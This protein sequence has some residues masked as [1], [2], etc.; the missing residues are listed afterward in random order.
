MA[1]SATGAS[2]L[3]HTTARAGRSSR[4]ARTARLGP[5]P[6]RARR[7]PGGRRAGERRLGERDRYLGRVGIGE[8]DERRSDGRRPASPS[9]PGRRRDHGD[10]QDGLVEVDGA[11]ERQLRLRHGRQRAG[12]HGARRLHRLE[13]RRADRGDGRRR[14]RRPAHEPRVLRRRERDR[15]LRPGR[16]LQRRHGGCD[17]ARLAPNASRTTGSPIARRSP[18]RAVR[19]TARTP[20]P[21]STSASP[22]TASS[23]TTSV[24]Y[25][26]TPAVDGDATLTLTSGF[27]GWVAVYTGTAVGALNAVV[28]QTGPTVRSPPASAPP[29]A[30]TYAIQV[31]AVRRRRRREHSRSDGRC[32]RSGRTDARLGDAREHER[33]ARLERTVVDRRRRDHG[34]QDLPRHL[35]AATRRLLTTVGNVTVF[36]DTNVVERRDLLVP[37]DRR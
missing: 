27:S 11:G 8:R 30:T 37:G 7:A 22:A 3:A 13:R 18:A 21:R 5:V 4:R 34:L 12:G 17:R 2:A 35:R 23:S 20:A 1:L 36:N 29:A 19:P 26:W 16:E 32:A 33:R 15:L 28:Q 9:P 24:W 10:G 25:S 6:R 31:G 14:R